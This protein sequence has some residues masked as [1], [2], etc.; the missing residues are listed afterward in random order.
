MMEPRIYTP[1]EMKKLVWEGG[2][3]PIRKDRGKDTWVFAKNPK[4]FLEEW[5]M[6]L[7]H[8]QSLVEKN[9][10]DTLI[11]VDFKNKKVKKDVA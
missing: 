2:F 9:L 8:Y 5:N 10:K 7:E 4:R 3:L 1:E 6:S 11:E